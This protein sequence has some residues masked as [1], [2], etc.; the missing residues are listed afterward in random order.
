[1]KVPY[2]KEKRRSEMTGLASEF[3]AAIS[4]SL[5]SSLLATRLKSGWLSNLYSVFALLQ[6][7]AKSEHTL[8]PSREFA[9]QGAKQAQ[10]VES[11]LNAIN[12]FQANPRV[13][14]LMQQAYAETI[15]SGFIAELQ[16]D[17]LMSFLH[18]LMYSYRGT[19][20]SLRCA[21]EDLYRHLYYMDHPQEFLALNE[22][23]NS[24]YNMDLSPQ[25]FREYMKRAS[26]LQCFSD[27]DVSFAPKQHLENAAAMDLFGLN[28][29]VYGALSAAVHGASKEWFAGLQNSGSLRGLPDKESKL[30]GIG[31]KFSKLCATFLIAAHR[32]T[33]STAGEYDKSIVLDLYSLDERKNLRRLLNI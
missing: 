5:T 2:L 13:L 33:F 14:S 6:I 8:N 19:A 15:F 32:N 7:L 23:R 9:L 28:E 11:F 25:R 22:G 3:S 16:S 17:L 24:E 29:E 31:S 4:S 18:G 12:G 30:E 1:M 21:L 10:D 26:Y 20:I 27:V